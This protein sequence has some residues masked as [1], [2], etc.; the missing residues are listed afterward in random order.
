VWTTTKRFLCIFLAW[1]AMAK[2]QRPVV[3]SFLLVGADHK[4][5]HFKDIIGHHRSLIQEQKGY[6]NSSHVAS[7]GTWYHSFIILRFCPWT[8]QWCPII[9]SSRWMTRCS[10]GLSSTLL[11]SPLAGCLPAIEN[12]TLL[13]LTLWVTLY[14]LNSGCDS[15][16]QFR[17]HW[18]IFFDNQ[19]HSAF[20]CTTSV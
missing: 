20:R 12:T 3:I 2:S 11:S 13:E 9:D 17:N 7:M 15:N 14:T 4:Q 5:Y 6:Q 8:N 18:Y 1:G 10:S 19:R 16:T